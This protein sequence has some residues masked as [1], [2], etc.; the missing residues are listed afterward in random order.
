MIRAALWSRTSAAILALA[1][2]GACVAAAPGADYP[3]KSIRLIVPNGVGGSTDLVSRTLAQKLSEGLGQ[4][5]IVDNRGGSGGII[6]TEMVARAQPDGYTL[7]IGT[8]G[9]LA[10]SPH[11]YKKLGYDALKDFAPVAQFSA[12][13]YMVLV[14][15]TLPAKSVKELVALARARPGQL[16]YA[17]AGSGTGSHL[18]TELFLSVAAIKVTHVPYKSGAAMT[19]SVLSDESQ[20]AF[21]GI[22]S[23]L[24]PMRGGKVRVLAVT[25]PERVAVAPEIPTIAEAGFPA[26]VSTSWT[27]LLAPAGTPKAVIAKLNA[28][29]RKALQSADVKNVLTSAGAEPIAATPEQFAAYLKTE[30]VKWGKVVRATGATAD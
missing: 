22:T 18:A 3:N 27:G 10:I 16:R 9:N 13:A 19:T 12:A 29:V 7:L 15:P 21:N 6:G 23:S 14:H 20:L 30:L 5:I 2:A 28:E 24:P 26:A 8:I 25:T 1:A 11:L 4:A 17:S